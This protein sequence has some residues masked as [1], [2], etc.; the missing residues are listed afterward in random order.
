MPEITFIE[1]DGNER[2][3]KAEVGVSLM[4]VAIANGVR[5]IDADCGGSCSC[6]TCHGYIAEAWMEKI[7]PADYGEISM[8]DF[9]FD[10]MDNSRLTCQIKVTPEMDGMLITLPESQG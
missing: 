2:T 10:K 6:A 5:G 9:V 7:E 3:V 4:E 8:L 1:P